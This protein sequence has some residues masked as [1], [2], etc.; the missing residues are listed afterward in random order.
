MLTDVKIVNLII[1]FHQEHL[2]L[3]WSY[4]APTIS[5]TQHNHLNEIK[6]TN[7]TILTFDWL[8]FI[9]SVLIFF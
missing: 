1:I 5:K 9:R 6:K 4:I 3:K 7:L 2:V 8:F